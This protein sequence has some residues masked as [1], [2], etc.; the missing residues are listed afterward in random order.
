MGQQKLKVLCIT[1]WCRNGSTII[2][3]ILNEVSGAFH[4]GELHFLWKNATGKGANNLCGCGLRLTECPVWSEVL[5]RNTPAGVT[6]EEHARAVVKRQ[7]AYVRTRHTWKVLSRG[8][9]E[10]D[11]AVHSVMLEKTYKD[12]ASITNSNFIIDTSKMPAESALFSYMRGIDA[13]YVHLVR[14]PRAAANSWN[15]PKQYI[16]TMSPARS[17]AYWAGF[18][19]AS[20]ALTR[21]NRER[22]LFM[23]YEDFIAD[24]S[25]TIAHLLQFSGIDPALNPVSGRTVTLGKNHTVT[26][27]PD[28]FRTGPTVIRDQDDSW[29]KELPASALAQVYAM[30]LPW[31]L[32]YGYLGG[33]GRT[34]SP[35]REAGLQTS[36]NS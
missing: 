16:H 5:A 15:A 35:V 11:I 25:G 22:S 24:P 34:K 32:R 8:A 18:N 28:R 10:R 29:R 12:I 36:R 4:V 17:T 14:D 2:G 27:N 1:G 13:Y 20:H 19:M 7:Q 6:L 26:G 23:K 31:M 33:S 9:K 30:S 21:K 3:N